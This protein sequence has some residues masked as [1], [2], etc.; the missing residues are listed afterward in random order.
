[1]TRS[2]KRRSYRSARR[3]S[4]LQRHKMA[5]SAAG[6]L[7][8]GCLVAAVANPGSF[9]PSAWFGSEPETADL[10]DDRTPA[11]PDETDAVR[12]SLPQL[13]ETTPTGD[14]SALPGS[15]DPAGSELVASLAPG[16]GEE[17]FFSSADPVPPAGEFDDDGTTA[18]G[19]GRSVSGSFNTAGSLYPAG[20]PGLLASLSGADD[21]L[22]PGTPG[23]SGFS[24]TAT[25]R[26]GGDPS[27]TGGDGTGEPGDQ[28]AGG[29]DGD[30]DGADTGRKDNGGNDGGKDD[31]GDDPL[32]LTKNDPPPAGTGDGG[33]DQV[34]ATQPIEVPE[35]GTLTLLGPALAAV[36]IARRRKARAV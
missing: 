16:E 18:S 29:G 6:I 12:R 30:G 27:L 4:F 11:S 32:D 34:D 1:M 13:A 15:L 20:G 23:A 14:P 3:K 28:T 26:S 33:W 17:P 25:N 31:G 19:P 7:L 21:F 36:W 22:P 8:Y 24:P 35:P 10:L 2:R 5:L 9:A